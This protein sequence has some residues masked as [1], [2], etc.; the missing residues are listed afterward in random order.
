MTSLLPPNASPLERALEAVTARISAVALPTH[1][2]IDPDRFPEALLPW[3]AWAL[4]LD[5]WNP[6]WP[7]DVKRGQLRHAITIQR[8]KGTV[9]CINQLVELFGGHV[10]VREWWQNEPPGQ[11]HTFEMVLSVSDQNTDTATAHY[12][13]DVIAAVRRAK[14]VRSHFTFTQ[15]LT[16]NASIHLSGASTT[17]TYRRLECIETAPEKHA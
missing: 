3:M 4:S 9:G 2:L 17:V 16:A 14:P 6:Q 11:P 12:V 13:D 8:S 1:Q 10:S 5:T 15:G 7:L